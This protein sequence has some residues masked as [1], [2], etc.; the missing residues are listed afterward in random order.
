[1]TKKEWET[2]CEAQAIGDDAVIAE[3]EAKQVA[4]R[5]A[6]KL[7]VSLVPPAII[8]EIAKVRQ[9]GNQKYGDPENWKQVEMQRYWDA[10]LRHILA[11]W[12]DLKAIDPE[13]GLKHLSHAACNLA[14]I[15]QML[16]DTKYE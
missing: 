1:M 14:F 8:M 11:A 5:D 12:D 7:P 3:I 6:G 9:Y 16:E 15:L 10:C 4:K 13:S 2:Y